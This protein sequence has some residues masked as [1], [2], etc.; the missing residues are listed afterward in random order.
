MNSGRFGK[1][2]A[3]DV[4]AKTWRRTFRQKKF[5]ET[6]RIFLPKRLCRNVLF[7]LQA[8][9]QALQA[10]KK[11]NQ[12]KRR[13]FPVSATLGSIMLKIGKNRS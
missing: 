11:D 2:M 3:A 9:A 1:N 7:P 8:G 4:S 5:A 13:N 12:A 6:S 10:P